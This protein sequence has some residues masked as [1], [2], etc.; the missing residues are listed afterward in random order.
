MPG[1]QTF[2]ACHAAR[3]VL[4][5]FVGLLDGLRRQTLA[6]QHH[7]PP[8]QAPTPGPAGLPITEHRA[9]ADDRATDEAIF[10]A[11]AIPPEDP[12]RYGEKIIPLIKGRPPSDATVTA[13]R[14]KAHRG[15]LC[16]GE[17]F[18]ECPVRSIEASCRII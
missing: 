15:G 17:A 7:A 9:V 13:G 2:V 12:G 1:V 11:H 3:H 14:K 18:N 4:E 5:G 10:F 8:H 16:C 6:A